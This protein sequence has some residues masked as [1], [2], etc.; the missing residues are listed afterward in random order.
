MCLHLKG[1]PTLL[2]APSHLPCDIA[3][4]RSFCWRETIILV[5][6]KWAC[7]KVAYEQPPLPLFY[8]YHYFPDIP[9]SSKFQALLFFLVPR[10][11][12]WFEKYPS[13]SG[14]EDD[15]HWFGWNFRI[16]ELFSDNGYKYGY[17]IQ[18]SNSNTICPISVRY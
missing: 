4:A 8:H 7:N 1:R 17:F 10:D 18:I 12:I 3:C 11:V 9:C 5:E 14:F 2:C 15:E 6:V 16:S 13:G